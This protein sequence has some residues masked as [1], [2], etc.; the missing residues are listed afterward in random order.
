MVP[1]VLTAIFAPQKLR[2]A[3]DAVTGYFTT[4][5]E[6]GEELTRV[7]ERLDSLSADI[8]KQRESNFDDVVKQANKD[9]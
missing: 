3:R 6:I 8:E 4:E 5:E 7:S 9:A 2:D 1:T